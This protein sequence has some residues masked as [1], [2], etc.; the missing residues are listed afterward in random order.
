MLLIDTDVLVGWLIPNELNPSTPS[1]TSSNSVD[2]IDA[3]LSVGNNSQR[4]RG[5]VTGSIVNERRG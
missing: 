4:G 2:T 3:N 5:A 1:T